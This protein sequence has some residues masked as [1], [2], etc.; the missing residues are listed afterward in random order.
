MPG[1]GHFPPPSRPDQRYDAVV[2][3]GERL[4]RR[5]RTRRALATTGVA[6]V[7]VLAVSVGVLASR[8]G[9]TDADPVARSTTTTAPPTDE[10]VVTA[11]VEDGAVSVDVDDGSVPTGDASLACVHVRVM[12][13]G[14]AQAPVAAGSACWYP[15][16]G[17][18]VTTTSM[19]LT[20]GTDVSCSATE[21]HPDDMAPVPATSGP[22]QHSFRFTLPAGM[23]SGSY[24]AEAV[25]VTG[26]G[27]GCPTSN[28][29]DTDE[30]AIAEVD[31]VV[32]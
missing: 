20:N 17:D 18:A 7:A 11:L 9:T 21:V 5:D 28:P 31:V 16:D 30:S 10:L 13:E 1:T 12:P 6:V 14:V 3:R 8:S 29:D 26:V 22:L 25:G 27:D 32:P 4:R 19:W 2:A 23:A 15:A 24:V